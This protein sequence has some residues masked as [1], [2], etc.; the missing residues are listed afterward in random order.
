MPVVGGPHD[1]RVDIV[2]GEDFLVVTS[3]EDV[4]VALAGG[5]QAAVEDVTRGQEFDAGDAERRVH[6]RH[7]HPARADHGQA[8]A[9]GRGHLLS[10][11][12]PS[13]SVAGGSRRVG[14]QERRYSR[15]ERRAG[16][17]GLDEVPPAAGRWWLAADL[18][19]GPEADLSD[20]THSASML[21]VYLRASVAH[22]L[23]R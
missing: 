20:F 19:S 6:V 10:R 14:S 23:V 16:R 22:R 3:R 11:R 12:P 7:A 9:V 17:D 21:M 8:D 18:S 5:V 13:E 1:D 4:P 2:A 15:G